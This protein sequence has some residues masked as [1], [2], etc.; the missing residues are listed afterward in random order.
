MSRFNIDTRVYLRN[1][2]RMKGEREKRDEMS[3]VK[4][5]R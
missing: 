3:C 2:S 5:E 1:C 4:S